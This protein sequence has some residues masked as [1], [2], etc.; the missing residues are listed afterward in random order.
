[1]KSHIVS[2]QTVK[3]TVTTIA[4]AAMLAC[5]AIG[6]T[7]KSSF[8]DNDWSGID[9]Q[10]GNYSD[11]NTGSGGADVISGH[12]SDGNPSGNTLMITTHVASWSP[13]SQDGHSSSLTEFAFD[14][15]HEYNPATQGA[16]TTVSMAIDSLNNNTWTGSGDQ[17]IGAA[18]G[19]TFALEQSGKT[20]LLKVGY[21][22]S[23][24]WTA[25]SYTSLTAGDFYLWGP[26]ASQFGV[27]HPDFTYAG[28]AIDFGFVGSNSTASFGSN[29]GTSVYYDNFSVD[30]YGNADTPEPGPIA[31]CAAGLTCVLRLLRKRRP[32][33]FPVA[34]G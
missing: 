13:I 12:S 11:G 31:L 5:P 6:Q 23:G 15:T 34:V 7:I 22:T 26:N 4:L 3:T 29:R 18:Q 30:V 2:K 28:S 16:I 14:K 8:H 17:N 24:S 19:S 21:L 1:M 27:E 33:K 10:S 32:G 20:Y 25:N 9:V